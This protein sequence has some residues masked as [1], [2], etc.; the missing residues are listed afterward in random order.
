M[1]MEGGEYSGSNITSGF[2]STVDLNV[3]FV[4]KVT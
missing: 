2:I 3:A 4:V 1:E